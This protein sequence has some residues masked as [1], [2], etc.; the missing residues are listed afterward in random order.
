MKLS[1][2]LGPVIKFSTC[3][4]SPRTKIENSLE[5]NFLF[6]RNVKMLGVIVIMSPDIEE[7]ITM[8]FLLGGEWQES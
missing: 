1:V 4:S 7:I 3:S 2:Y 8:M 5:N 6:L